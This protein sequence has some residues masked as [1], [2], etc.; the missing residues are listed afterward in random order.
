MWEKFNFEHPALIGVFGMLRGDGA[1]AKTAK[2][3][4]AKIRKLWNFDRV[5]GWD[6]PMLAMAAARTGDA[7][8]AVD[9]LLYPSKNFEFDEHGVATGGPCPYFP[10]NGGFLA[11]VAMLAGGWDGMEEREFSEESRAFPRGWKVEAEG[12]GRCQ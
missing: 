1:D 8:T 10:S 6:F 11:A 9:F 5:W 4:L 3:T 7:N 12:F 2:A